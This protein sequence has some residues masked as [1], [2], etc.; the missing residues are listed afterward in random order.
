[1]RAISI[2]CNPMVMPTA[3]FALILFFA[4]E[5]AKPINLAQSPYIILSISLTT[6]F[7][8]LMSL[9]M[10]KVTS[11]IS[12]IWLENRKERIL[13][14]SF[15]VAFYG[16]T[17][18]MFVSRIQVNEFLTV[19]LIAMTTIVITLAVI[20]IFI[21]VSVHS[22][23]ISSLVGFIIATIIKVPS[24]ELFFPLVISILVSGALMSARLS[25][26]RNTPFEIV[27]G[28]CL[29]LIIGLSS[30]LLFA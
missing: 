9:S 2:V 12:S 29:G 28:T 21:K 17:T 13:P 24:S 4:P 27:L 19:L 23:A 14:F 1:M 22:A 26:N 25:L 6:F 11:T 7:I 8:P 10:L 16:I 15:M 3:L 30:I 5:A 18:Y 20:S